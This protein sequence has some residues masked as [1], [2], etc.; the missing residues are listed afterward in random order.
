MHGVLQSKFLDAPLSLS[1]ARDL[2]TMYF[3][4]SPRGSDFINAKYILNRDV[5]G[6]VDPSGQSFIALFS[7]H[8]TSP[9]SPCCCD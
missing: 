1:A 7:C 9:L 5:V 2:I 8:L 6:Y 4:F 3:F